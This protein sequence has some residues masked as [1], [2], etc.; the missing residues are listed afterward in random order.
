MKIIWQSSGIELWQFKN[1]LMTFLQHDRRKM[2]RDLL[3]YI[4]KRMYFSETF[5]QVFEDG[6]A[7]SLISTAINS[8][9]KI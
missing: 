1:T 3:E 7:S 5:S 2:K 6:K 9:C 8:L 4:S